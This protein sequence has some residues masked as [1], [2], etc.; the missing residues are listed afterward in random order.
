MKILLTF[1]GFHDPFSDGPIAGERETGPVLTVNA[2]RHF[3]YV[4][5][6]STPSTE[7]VTVQVQ[8][9]LLKRHTDRKVETCD[10][11]LKDPT[12]YRGLFKQ[13]RTHFR[14]INRRNPEAEYFICV[15][16]GTPHMHA[17]WLML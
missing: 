9:E 12:N 17:C 10:V 14:Q 7:P 13:L 8:E 2:E 11:P 3:D 5:L 15:S 16:S 6:F 4:Y 1:T